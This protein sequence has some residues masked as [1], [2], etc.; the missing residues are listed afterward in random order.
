MPTA[1]GAALNATR[2]A[3]ARLRSKATLPPPTTPTKRA[4]PPTADS[5]SLTSSPLPRTQT[6]AAT[7]PLDGPQRSPTKRSRT[8]GGTLPSTPTGHGGAPAAPSMPD[9]ATPIAAS[10]KAVPLTTAVPEDVAKLCGIPNGHA[11]ALAAAMAIIY[12][13]DDRVGAAVD[14]ILQRLFYTV[15]SQALSAATASHPRPAAPPAA[16]TTTRPTYASCVATQTAPSTQA[17][18]KHT[19]SRQSNNTTKPPAREEVILHT[20]RLTSPPSCEAIVSAV[21]AAAGERANAFAVRRL[22]SGNSAIV[23]PAGTDRWYVKDVSWA[24]ALG[25]DVTD[26][27]PKVVVRSVPAD[28]LTQDLSTRLSAS[29]RILQSRPMLRNC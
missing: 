15:A 8:A 26:F 18:P 28:T 22:P 13:T 2:A 24:E 12:D 21:K 14:T 3:T 7:A 27:G 19:K 11:D 1:A 16:T 20:S 5:A 6:K 25:A 4:R 10:S 23:F 9:P 29:V 17:A